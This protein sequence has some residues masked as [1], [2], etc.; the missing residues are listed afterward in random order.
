MKF[1]LN[2]KSYWNENVI[3]IYLNDLKGINFWREVW[4]WNCF[5]GFEVFKKFYMLYEAY[6]LFEMYI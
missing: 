4:F 2:Y 6:E 3:Y 5:K 1:K